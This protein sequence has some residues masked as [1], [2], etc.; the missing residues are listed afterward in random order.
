MHWPGT[1]LP[2]N[3]V[4]NNTPS[5][6]C[7]PCWTNKRP[8]VGLGVQICAI[9]LS[10][11]SNASSSVHVGQVSLLLQLQHN[12]LHGTSKFEKNV[13]VESAPPFQQA[14]PQ[15]VSTRLG[16]VKAVLVM[17]APS[18]EDAWKLENNT[19]R[20]DFGNHERTHCPLRPNRA[21]TRAPASNK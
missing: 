9:T 17:N 1:S 19:N 5:S 16:N 3:A 6:K 2:E 4:D 18:V 7:W 8:P 15:L 11:S 12:H 14:S 10:W 13:C 21:S 20:R